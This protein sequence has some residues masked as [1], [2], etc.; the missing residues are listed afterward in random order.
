[1]FQ[2]IMKKG[3]LC[4]DTDEKHDDSKCYGVADL[5]AQPES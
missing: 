4:R 2:S 3:T 5:Q 1:M